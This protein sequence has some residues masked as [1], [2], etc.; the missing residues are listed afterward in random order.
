MSLSTTQLCLRLVLALLLPLFARTTTLYETGLSLIVITVI[1]AVVCVSGRTIDYDAARRF[2]VAFAGSLLVTYIVDFAVLGP[3]TR[4]LA[5][6]AI[7]SQALWYLFPG[8]TADHCVS[9]Q[10]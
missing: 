6:Y 8:V 1:V 2:T 7:A 9:L 3:W 4:L 5:T 10:V